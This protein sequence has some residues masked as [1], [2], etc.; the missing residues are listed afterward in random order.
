MATKYSISLG[1]I[2]KT[3]GLETVYAP[4]D[5]TEIMVTSPDVYRPG[6]ILSG[7]SKYFDPDRIQFLGIA[8]VEYLNSSKGRTEQER[9]RGFCLKSL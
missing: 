9:L 1:K 6:L 7:F 2:A 3:H 4:R 8:E 5:L